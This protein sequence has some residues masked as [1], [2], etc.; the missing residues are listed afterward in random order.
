MAVSTHTRQLFERVT[1]ALRALNTE[2]LDQLTREIDALPPDQ[3]HEIRAAIDAAFPLDD[4]MHAYA[5]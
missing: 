3:A 2:A 1:A 4:H 5:F